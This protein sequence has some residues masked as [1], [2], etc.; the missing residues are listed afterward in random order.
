MN[1]TSSA[2]PLLP[3]QR[4]RKWKAGTLA[5]LGALTIVLGAYAIGRTVSPKQTTER[6]VPSFHRLTFRRG[7]APSARF[8]P[9]GKTVV[10]AAVV[11]GDPVRVFSRRMERPE[12]FKLDLPDGVLKLCRPRASS[13]SCWAGISA[14]FGKPVHLARVPIGGGV[15]R[16]LA[17]DVLGA[18]WGPDGSIASVRKTGDASAWNIPKVT[19]STSPLRAS[20]RRASHAA[21]TWSRSGLLRAEHGS[22]RGQ[23]KGREAYVERRVGRIR[24][25]S[26]LVAVWR[27]SLVFRGS[28]DR[29]HLGLP[30]PCG[31]TVGTQ[32][33]LLRLPAT[34]YPQDVSPDGT[35]L[36]VGVGALRQVCRCLPPG[37]SHERDLSWFG[38]TSVSDLSRDARLVLLHEEVGG[39]G[40]TYLRNVDGFPP[41]RV[42]DASPL[43]LSPDGHWVVSIKD[44]QFVLVPTGAGGTRSL[45]MKGFD[46]ARWYPD[47]RH[48]SSR[49]RC[50]PPAEPLRR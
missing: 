29:I 7:G 15:A 46:I 3:S 20:T 28:S 44:D 37:E 35:Q 31:V 32:R 50:P 41:L 16:P 22:G 1:G 45:D 8:A 4:R 39:A 23:P 10:Y 24:P 9:D 49:Q 38:S 21:A 14:T 47:S 26:G 27:R 11:D 5:S 18:D 25:L 36:I 42:G 43:A 2:L 34:L 13:S 6:P 30:A 19:C 48:L 12:S 40:G 17:D 33:V